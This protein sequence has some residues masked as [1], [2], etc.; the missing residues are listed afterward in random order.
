MQNKH[1]GAIVTCAVVALLGLAAMPSATAVP[2]I[3]HPGIVAEEPGANTPN[4]QDGTVYAIARVGSKVVIGG[5][6]T[7]VMDRDSSTP[8][9]R[10]Y[11]LAFDQATGVVDPTF[12]P[13]LDGMVEA[14]SP[15]PDN[16]VFVGGGFSKVNG[17][18]T[19][20]ARLDLATGQLV[21]G[22]K[23]PGFDGRV[24]AL[25]FA[26]GR[27]F[28]GGAFTVAGNGNKSTWLPHA[29]LASLN[30]VTGTVDTYV[31]S[32][33]AGHHSWTPTNGWKSA[34]VGVKALDVSPTGTEMM[35]MGNFTS[36]DGVARD[37]IAKLRLESTGAVLDADWNTLAYT[38]LCSRS[39]DS[40]AREVQYSPD[41]S[42]FAT[43]ATGG[44][45]SSPQNVDGTR[46]NCDTTVRFD[47]AASGANVKPSWIARTGNDTFL[48]VAVTGKAVYVGGHMRW[49]NNSSGQD[50]P[51]QGAV[52]RPGIAA[53]DPLNGLPLKWNG[54]RHPRGV[55]AFALLA[56]E[57]GL[58]VGSD[59]DYVGN[60]K[61]FRGR[62]A[63]FPLDG[64]SQPT[65]T[66]VA[67]LPGTVYRA[68]GFGNAAPN[69]L[70]RVNVGGPALP[71]QDGGLS[72][73]S[74]SSDPSPYRRTGTTMASLTLAEVDA[75][76]PDDT[77]NA[78]FSTQRYD[79]GTAGDDKEMRWS[80]PVPAGTGVQVRLYFNESSMTA[81]GQR[82]FSVAADGTTTLMN[83]DVYSAAGRRVGTMR[84]FNLV[85]DG[86]VDLEFLHEVNN[87]M[88]SGIEIVQQS[89]PA[90]ADEGVPIYRLNAGG[91]LVASTDNGP[92][93][94]PDT[95]GLTTQGSPWRAGGTATVYSTPI[96]GMD[97][98]VP[99][100][101]PPSLFE[102][103]VSTTGTQRYSLPVP[104]GTEVRLRL[105]W[106]NQSKAKSQEGRV[107]DVAVDGTT[108][109]T[110]VDVVARAGG[111]QRATMAEVPV[112]SDGRIDV[113]FVKG[114]VGSPFINAVEVIQTSASPEVPADAS[115]DA[116]G[117]AT[118]DGV[119]ASSPAAEA[120]GEDWHRVRGAF[121]LGHTLYYG[122]DNGTLRS[123]SIVGSSFGPPEEINPYFDPVWSTV[124]TGSTS[125]VQYYRG[126]LPAFYLGEVESVSSLFYADGRI[127]FT[128]E[129]KPTMYSRYFS[130]DS[131]AVGSDLFT[132]SDG[133]DW[134]T[135]GGAFLS[136]ASLYYADRAD[137]SLKVVP[138]NG[139]MAEGTATVVDAS[140]N[141]S[142]R[143]LFLLPAPGELG[144]VSYRASAA[145]L[146]RSNT[147][148]VTIPASVRSGDT[149]LLFAT[150]NSTAVT[151]AAPAGWQT[152]GVQDNGVGGIK[153]MLFTKRAVGT[154]AGS[155]VS[156]A[157][158]ASTKTSMT[159]AAY[160]GADPLSVSA[161]FS[162]DANTATHVAPSSEAGDRA[163]SIGYFADKSSVDPGT[164]TWTAP[165]G[166]VARASVPADAAPSVSSLLADTGGGLPA[167]ATPTWTATA[168]STS[169]RGSAW[170][171]ILAP[172][173]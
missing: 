21:K 166:M 123:R 145:A 102:S 39:F 97:S 52:P 160:Q 171:V 24:Q 119:N 109:L 3:A 49:L 137:G 51:G 73:A 74:D 168:D 173:G 130:P 148:G 113:D 50:A 103:E 151:V 9:S 120:W 70:Y 139:A 83:L 169:V 101:T 58:Y 28:A 100:S 121:V 78:L 126:V 5:D 117:A 17:T 48:S 89:R 112:T 19:K 107:F 108:R 68:G 162:A 152:M 67:S 118:F 31:N 72:W 14:L 15:G 20:L 8:V 35:V 99:A 146:V 71:A 104:A 95:T 150:V 94:A 88:V 79:A 156:V 134:S 132:V 172:P 115:A 158:D 33:L 11:I 125:G 66:S 42:Y 18:S 91:A 82:R 87:P 53:L 37:Q 38:A 64:G 36:I 147:P 155:R 27:L 136:G 65:S 111:T 92:S 1:I 54:G 85:S 6:F 110:N 165:A 13:V 81:A 114:A 41:G 61:Y 96:T 135:V 75:T 69:S 86:V 163:W 124:A 7:T 157:L 16:T 167:G 144:N 46:S 133:R 161:S 59:T 77:P 80:F 40:Y 149:L 129:G 57:E 98:T 93:W 159:V 154:D 25:D 127:Y 128:L 90:V 142:A 43:V 55:G 60:R 29:G 10:P 140:A 44:G 22:W 62:V 105:Y 63:F 164:R 76:V 23:K 143:A 170:N 32:Q 84:S 106:A 56:T 26:A 131:G 12:T 2:N 30:P 4:V 138:W 34:P 141:W 116:I 153:T 45:G 122:W 47:S